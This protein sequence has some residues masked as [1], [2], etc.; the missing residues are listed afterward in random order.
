MW[1]F[2]VSTIPSSLLCICRYF[3]LNPEKC[4]LSHQH[5]IFFLPL[6]RTYTLHM[7][8]VS[9]SSS[10]SYPHII[11]LYHMHPSPHLHSISSSCHSPPHNVFLLPLT[12]FPSPPHN[13][14]LLLP[15]T[16]T[17]YLPSLSHSSSHILVV[18]LFFP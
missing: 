5:S 18:F 11:F 7:H 10:H 4:P 16:S 6:S 15:L 9:F 17:Q 14:F 3:K 13:V 1:K 2:T 8:T 12:P